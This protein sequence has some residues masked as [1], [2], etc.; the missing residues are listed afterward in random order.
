MTNDLKIHH[1][2]PTIGDLV[3][4]YEKGALN[5]SPTFQ[6]KSVWGDKDRTLLIQSLL[7]GFPIPAIFLYQRHDGHKLC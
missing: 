6:R 1:E 2:T 4:R 3:S 5:L 7:G